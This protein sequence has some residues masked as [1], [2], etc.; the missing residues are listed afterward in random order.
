DARLQH[1]LGVAY[2]SDG[3]LYV[4]DTY[5]NKIKRLDLTKR[6]IETF[7]GSGQEG[8]TD[9]VADEASFDE[10]AGMS[11][12]GG[13]IYVADTNNHLIRVVDLKSKKVST[14]MIKWD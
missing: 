5:N 13:K 3:I 14:F 4:A 11:I 12:A 2:D 6:R 7:A 1:P 10:P 8:R 9:G